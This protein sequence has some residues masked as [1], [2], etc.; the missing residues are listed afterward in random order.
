MKNYLKWWSKLSYKDKMFFLAEYDLKKT[1][2]AVKK[3]DIK[4]IYQTK[5]VTL[6]N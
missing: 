4:K 6:N 3:E 5:V 1:I 2:I